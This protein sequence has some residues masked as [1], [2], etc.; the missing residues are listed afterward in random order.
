MDIRKWG[1]RYRDPDPEDDDEI[2]PDRP[3]PDDTP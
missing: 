3:E 2:P 1:R